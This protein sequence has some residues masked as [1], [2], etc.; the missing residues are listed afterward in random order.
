M[1]WYSTHY[2]TMILYPL[3]WL[4]HHDT[5]PTT[6]P[7]YS[8]YTTVILYPLHYHDTL[9]TIPPWYYIHYTTLILYPLHHNDTLPIILAWYYHVIYPIFVLTAVN[10]NN[11]IPS[12]VY[13]QCL[14]A[15]YSLNMV[16]DIYSTYNKPVGCGGCTVEHLTVNWGDGGSI[17]PITVLKLRQFLS[18]HIYLCLSEET[19]KA[20]PFYLVSMPGQLCNL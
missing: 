12:R 15:K 7:W 9:P 18:P 5:L 2:T 17:P 4:H 13:G 3:L 6:P 8:T 19:L 10:I 14:H 1:S 20:V 11:Y 16:R